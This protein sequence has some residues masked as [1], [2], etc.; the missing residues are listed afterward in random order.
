MR[1]QRGSHRPSRQ[2]STRAWVVLSTV[3]F[4]ASCDKHPDR[5][6]AEGPPLSAAGAA[7]AAAAAA[8]A[9]EGTAGGGAGPTVATGGVAG[10]RSSTGGI[11]VTS[12]AAGGRSGGGE[13]GEETV[14]PPGEVQQ[15]V[16][17]RCGTRWRICG[18]GPEWSGCYDQFLNSECTPEEPGYSVPAA[19]C[20]KAR[21]LCSSRTCS[22]LVAEVV[23]TKPCS[24]G[25]YY[26]ARPCTVGD[27]EGYARPSV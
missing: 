7:A 20:G 10:Q 14:C 1:Q 3:L 11:A 13:G 25:E 17:G 8:S 21:Y 26:V 6:S 27:V 12:G 16:C 5:G 19:Q 15:E 23:E 24:P 18:E 4:V 2:A 9:G 22:W